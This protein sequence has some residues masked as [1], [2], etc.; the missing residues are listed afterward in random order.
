MSRNVSGF[1]VLFDFGA[2]PGKS[3]GIYSQANVVHTY[4]H[5]VYESLLDHD[6]MTEFIE[7]R[8]R[9]HKEISEYLKEVP[10][11]MVSLVISCGWERSDKMMRNVSRVHCSPD[12]VKLSK[13]LCESLYD[14]GKSYV[15]NHVVSDPVV[16]PDTKKTIIL[17]PFALN[18]ENAHE[19]LTR[20]D[21]LGKDIGRTI[22]EWTREY[23][24]AIRKR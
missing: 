7:T 21:T 15:F 17:K 16:I 2:E 13:R 12:C 5:V 3:C 10:E 8:K 4:G 23:G 6:V 22:G 1:A 14:W 20:L 19:Y 24:I 11:Y 9:P 18:G